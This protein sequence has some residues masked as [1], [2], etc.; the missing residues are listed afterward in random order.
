MTDLSDPDDRSIERGDGQVSDIGRGAF[1]FDFENKVVGAIGAGRVGR[2]V[3]RRS[4][5]I[6][7]TPR[8]SS[9]TS[10]LLFGR[11]R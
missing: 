9:T 2:L 5:P 6:I 10:M 7:V 8:S 11:V 1:D 4:R 3:L